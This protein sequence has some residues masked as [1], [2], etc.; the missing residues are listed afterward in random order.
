M[1]RGVKMKQCTCCSCKYYLQRKNFC[2]ANQN[3]TS[4]SHSC[5]PEFEN[6]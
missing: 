1:K 6:K 4:C 2:M 5:C 3:A